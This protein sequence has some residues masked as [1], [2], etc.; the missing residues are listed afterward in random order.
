MSICVDWIIYKNWREIGLPN[1]ML[2]V[3][4]NLVVEMSI[5]FVA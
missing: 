1:Q 3:D 2:R 4:K 5:Q